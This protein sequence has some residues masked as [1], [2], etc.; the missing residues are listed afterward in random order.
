MHTKVLAHF[1]QFPFDVRLTT[2]RIQFI[3]ELRVSNTFLHKFLIKLNYIS[4]IYIVCSLP[5]P[6]M[7]MSSAY[8]RP[9][10]TLRIVRSE[11]GLDPIPC[12]TLSRLLVHS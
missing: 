10:H 6:N 7:R 11:L 2:N 12:P 8:V 4:R 1:V 5:R 3:S 9:L